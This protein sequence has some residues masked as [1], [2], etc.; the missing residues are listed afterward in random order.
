MLCEI[1]QFNKSVK[2]FVSSRD[3]TDIRG[4]LEIVSY[5]HINAVDNTA[6]IDRFVRRDVTRSQTGYSMRKSTRS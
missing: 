2:I 1:T 6:D 5:V 4:M 3:E